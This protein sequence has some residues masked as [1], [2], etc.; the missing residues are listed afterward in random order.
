MKV[1][2]SQKKTQTS[3]KTMKIHLV[4]KMMIR[5][6]DSVGMSLRKMHMMMTSRLLKEGNKLPTIKGLK[7]EKVEDDLLLL[8]L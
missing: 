2:M 6:K 7:R 5:V 3:Q 1:S 8:S 4:Y